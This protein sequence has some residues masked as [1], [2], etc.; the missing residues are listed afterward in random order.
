MNRYCIDA[1]NYL[2]KIDEFDISELKKFIDEFNNELEKY[3]YNGISTYLLECIEIC[4]KLSVAVGYKRGEVLTRWLKGHVLFM[5]GQYNLSL[6]S[7][8]KS[9]SQLNDKDPEYETICGSYALNLFCIGELSKSLEVIVPLI[10]SGDYTAANL[11][12][13]TI[14][15]CR[16]EELLS[17]SVMD[18]EIT[19]DYNQTFQK[20]HSLLCIR[21]VDEAETLLNSIIKY[22]NMDNTFYKSYCESIK[23]RISILRNQSV[24]YDNLIYIKHGLDSK[25]SFYHFIDGCLNLAEAFL[26]VGNVDEAVDILN[27][28]KDGKRQLTA[29]DCRLHKLLEQACLKSEDFKGAYTNSAIFSDIIRKRNSYDVDRTLRSITTFLYKDASCIC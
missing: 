18:K 9:V 6:N 3:S 19:T 25:K 5:G 10:K 8:K 7:Y 23:V 14:L 24:D 11:I 16:G 26:Y 22:I 29:F 17:Y 2:K 1:K 12:L 21:R 4:L 28:V 27:S 20:I 15:N 13:S